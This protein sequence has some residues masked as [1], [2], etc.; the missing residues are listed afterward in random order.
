MPDAV[1]YCGRH[2]SSCGYCGRA[3]ETSS[4]DGAVAHALA[5]STYGELIDDGWRRSGRWLYKPALEA[6]CC[7]QRTIRVRCEE[8]APSKSQRKVMRRLE[9]FLRATE[10]ERDGES[11]GSRKVKGA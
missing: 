3:G 4:S 5:A 9:T 7:A 11:D 10:R 1:T 2:A 8:F 6:S